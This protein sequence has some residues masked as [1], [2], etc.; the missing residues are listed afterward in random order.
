MATEKVFQGLAHPFHPK[1]AE[2]VDY[3][4]NSYTMTELLTYFGGGVAAVLGLTWI[5]VSLFSP[6]LGRWDKWAVLWFGLCELF[7]YCQSTLALTCNSGAIIH[8][9]FE[10]YYSF[11]HLRMGPAQDLFGQL[12]KEYSLSDS[13]YLTNDPF[14][15][16]METVTAVSPANL[17]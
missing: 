16:C 15:L 1:D 17:T 10:G 14:V 11:N 5:L 7:I 8:T 12:W 13:R 9:F 2:I 3:L 6:K 4:A